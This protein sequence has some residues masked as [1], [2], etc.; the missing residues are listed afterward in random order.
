M[1][2]KLF[3][4]AKFGIVSLSTTGLDYLLFALFRT[5]L[6]LPLYVAVFVA[7]ALSSFT[8]YMLNRKVVFAAGD[9]LSI[10]KYYALAVV[11]A[12]L[13]YLGIR[14]FSAL[15][16]NEYLAKIISDTTLFLFSYTV[17]HRVIF[18]KSAPD[19]PKPTDASPRKDP[20]A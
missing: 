9:R 16:L 6:S 15:G 2:Q 5:V 8:N 19:T 20:E 11:I 10:V 1:L 7:R 12:A 18:K 4:F 3:T 13:S 14:L 17:Q